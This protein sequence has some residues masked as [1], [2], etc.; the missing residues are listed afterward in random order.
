[1]LQIDFKNA[2]DHLFLRSACQKFGMLAL[3]AGR[4]AVA[5]VMAG[6]PFYLNMPKI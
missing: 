6:E 5:Q 3:G 2:D 4:L 1:L